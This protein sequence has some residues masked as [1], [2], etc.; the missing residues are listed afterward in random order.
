METRGKVEVGVPGFVEG[1]ME[2]APITVV[3]G[4]GNSMIARLTRDVLSGS[5]SPDVAGLLHEY[6]P[7]HGDYEVRVL[8]VEWGSDVASIVCETET[9]DY[10]GV[11]G[12]IRARPLFL[13]PELEYAVRDG[14]FPIDYMEWSLLYNELA[15]GTS[16]LPM[17]VDGYMPVLERLGEPRLVSRRG[18][19]YV[20]VDGREVPLRF[21][22]SSSLRLSV[23]EE[24]LR[25]GLLD[26]YTHLLLDNFEAGL[27]P[28]SRTKLA[29]ML[30]VLAR[31]G[32]T[33][34]V[35]THDVVFLD[36]LTHIS[37]VAE[38]LR[39]LHGVNA[40]VEP[41]D[42]AIYAIEDGRLRRYEPTAS[43]IRDY[44]PY[45]YAAF[46]Y[47]VEEI[48]QGYARFSRA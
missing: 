6:L 1:E 13:A 47:T 11:I 34:I 30:H 17:C 14:F 16:R 35:A 33:V 21:A 3:L 45:V 24:A 42:V 7:R 39:R 46:G 20:T 9:G 29:L 37:S 43:F 32:K 2:L 27:H 28:L 23:L 31:C 26:D 5:L 8:M 19:L 38:T 12:Y 25:R 36:M 10:C 22:I 18:E 44:T 41:V 40:K 48:G 15:V 4:R